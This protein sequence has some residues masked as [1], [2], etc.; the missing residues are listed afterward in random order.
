MQ[1]PSLF[2]LVSSLL[3]FTLLIHHQIISHYTHAEAA[4]S[5]YFYCDVAHSD[6]IPQIISNVATTMVLC[7]F[8]KVRVNN[9]Q[10]KNVNELLDE[11]VDKK[12]CIQSSDCILPYL[13]CSPNTFKCTMDGTR[14][15]GDECTERWNCIGAMYSDGINCFKGR[16]TLLD[17]NYSLPIGSSCTTNFIDIDE[18]FINWKNNT[19]STCEIGS[20]CISGYCHPVNVVGLYE[21]C[22]F[23]YPNTGFLSYTIVDVCDNGLYCMKNCLPAYEIPDFNFNNRWPFY[24]LFRNGVSCRDG[25]TPSANYL[26]P[27]ASICAVE[28][29]FCSVNTEPSTCPQNTRFPLLDTYSGSLPRSILASTRYLGRSSRCDANQRCSNVFSKRVSDKCNENADCASAVCSEGVCVKNQNLGMDCGPSSNT[30]CQTFTYCSCSNSTQGQCIQFCLKEFNDFQNCILNYRMNSVMKN[31]KKPIPIIDNKSSVISLH[32]GIC[33]DYLNQ[34][35]KCMETGQ[36]N[37]DITVITNQ[38]TVKELPPVIFNDNVSKF[39]TDPLYSEFVTS[40]PLK[41]EYNMNYS[42]SLD[43]SQISTSVLDLTSEHDRERLSIT[44]NIYSNVNVSNDIGIYVAERMIGLI[45]RYKTKSFSFSNTNINI[46]PCCS[47][48]VTKLVSEF[49]LKGMLNLVN[50]EDSGYLNEHQ[51][52]TSDIT[53]VERENVLSHASFINR[54]WYQACDIILVQPQHVDEITIAVLNN[55]LLLDNNDTVSD[56]SVENI[57]NMNMT[58]MFT[59]FISNIP[60]ILVTIP[61]KV[62]DSALVN[63]TILNKVIEKLKLSVEEPVKT[64]LEILSSCQQDDHGCPACNSSVTIKYFIK[65]LLSVPFPMQRLLALPQQSPKLIIEFDWNV[66]TNLI[67]LPIYNLEVLGRIPNPQCFSAYNMYFGVFGY[68]TDSSTFWDLILKDACLWL[69]ILCCIIFYIPLFTRF[70]Y[71]IGMKRRSFLPYLGP[72]CIILV[73]ILN[74]EPVLISTFKILGNSGLY[75]MIGLQNAGI[76]FLSSCYLVI[77]T[78]F[79]LLRNLYKIRITMSKITH[80]EWVKKKRVY[81]RFA[82]NIAIVLFVLLCCLIVFPVFT[83]VYYF[84]VKSIVFKNQIFEWSLQFDGYMLSHSAQVFILSIINILIFTV[85]ATVNWE[86]IKTKVSLMLRFNNLYNNRDGNTLC[87]SM[88]LSI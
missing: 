14:F 64:N 39:V 62:R 1:S 51:I 17:F 50:T 36:S 79:Y 42:S 28:N 72:L 5:P 73:C 67:N 29:T 7:P 75:L 83:L 74:I 70:R 59:L 87:F 47:S 23:L 20:R 69:L 34:Y 12:N 25:L 19:V 43:I 45:P 68:R 8:G 41:V 27:N 52:R 54:N 46:C 9:N 63:E 86:K 31:V 66:V 49:L 10:C 26:F 32:N 55:M 18:R 77:I 37:L 16:C 76:S 15:L 38:V 11:M 80:A 33:K 21:K 65:Q 71:N 53:I 6:L 30:K 78:R 58:S 88:I 61:R 22:T 84:I 81:D 35:H 85:D 60:T 56:Q 4:S 40:I 82:G 3:I 48:N 2:P 44:C 24:S 57:E 13:Y